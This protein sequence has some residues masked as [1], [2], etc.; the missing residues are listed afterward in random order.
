MSQCLYINS[1]QPATSWVLCWKQI[2]F[3]YN[4]SLTK[5]QEGAVCFP[6]TI[7]HMYHPMFAIFKTRKSRQF[8]GEFL[9]FVFQNKRFWNNGLTKSFFKIFLHSPKL[10]SNWRLKQVIKHTSEHLHGRYESN[11]SQRPYIVQI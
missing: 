4:S 7:L 3:Q 1:F 6:H 11:D 9:H 10:N 8:F 5:L 2:I